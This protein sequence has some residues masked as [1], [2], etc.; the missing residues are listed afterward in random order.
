VRGQAELDTSRV[1]PWVGLVVSRLFL[2]SCVGSGPSSNCVGLCR[3]PVI[4]TVMLNIVN[5]QFR[6]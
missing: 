3:S 6:V 4:Q 1:H 2:A 5:G